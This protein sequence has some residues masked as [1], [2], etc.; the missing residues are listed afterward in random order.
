MKSNVLILSKKKCI[1]QN[2]SRFFKNYI[3]K[4]APNLKNILVLDKCSQIQLMF[5]LKNY[6]FSKIVLK[7]KHVPIFENCSKIQK[8]LVFL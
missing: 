1:F 6:T 4:N 3:L 7:G 2:C 5:A 8:M